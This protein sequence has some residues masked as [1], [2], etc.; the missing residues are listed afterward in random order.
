M[1]QSAIWKFPLTTTEDQCVAVPFGFRPLTVEFDPSG[2]LCLW[3]IAYLETA[4]TRRRLFV[5][6]T[7]HVVAHPAAKEYIGTAIDRELGLVWHV[8]DGGAA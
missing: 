5:Y 1:I 8:F 7:G 3:A 6:G 4:Q 2:E